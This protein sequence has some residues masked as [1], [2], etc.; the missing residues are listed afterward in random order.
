MMLLKKTC[1]F[2]KKN[3]FFV[4]THAH[5][6]TQEFDHDIESVIQRALQNGVE[7]IVLP[8]IDNSHF[9]QMVSLCSKFP[10][11]LYPMIGVH[12]SSIRENSDD[13]LKLVENELK[14]GNYCAIGETGIDLY[15][16]KTFVKQQCEAFEFHLNLALQNNL[17]V[18]I[19]Q[20]ESFKE[21]LDILT[22][23]EYKSV[24]GIFH[25]YAGDVETAKKCI[26]MGFLLGI[27]GVVTYKKSLMAE[28][29]SQIP[30]DHLVLETDAP[31]LPPV[32]FRGK[33]NEPSYIP[34]I[35]EKIAEIQLVDIEKVAEVTTENAIRL[36]KI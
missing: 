36:F 35:A 32:P 31:Y 18:V 12:P 34:I 9:Q 28:V 5:I 1:R 25:C 21:I 22:M 14:K 10:N 2:A 20:R 24:R 16:D 4:D 3:M 17:P 15:W 30:L 27:G 19:H 6:Y 13:E 11:I 23:S 26:N 33:R 29:V 8:S 7:K